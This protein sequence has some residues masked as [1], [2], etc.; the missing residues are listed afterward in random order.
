[1]MLGLSSPLNWRYGV[2]RAISH[3]RTSVSEAVLG[4]LPHRP[5]TSFGHYMAYVRSVLS[6]SVVI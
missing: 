4:H 5:Q 2:P 3:F 6:V 1:M